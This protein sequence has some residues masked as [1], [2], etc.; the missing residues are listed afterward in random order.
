MAVFDR[1]V[2]IRVAA[3]LAPAAV[4]G[5]LWMSTRPSRSLPHGKIEQLTSSRMFE[6]QPS[7]SPDGSL[8]AFRCDY[9]GNSDICVSTIADNIVRNLTSESRDDESSPS[10]SPDGRTIAFQSG[11]R[12]VFTV[13]VQG[14][15]MTQVTTTGGS[16]AWTPDGRSI[17]YSV[18]TIPGALFRE[19][20]TE[21]FIVDAATRAARR[22]PLVADF[23][24]PAVSPRGSRIAYSG[25]QVPRT[26]RRAFN[27]ASPDLWTVGLDG[28]QAVRVTNDV[29]KESSPMWSADGRFLYFVSDRNGSSAIWRVAIDERTGQPKGRPEPVPT[30]YSQPVRIT[31][32]ADGSRLAWSDALAVERTMRIAFDAEAR[33]T[34]G[35][36]VE[37]SPGTPESDDAEPAADPRPPRAPAGTTNPAMSLAALA[38]PGRWSPDRALYAGTTSGAV[39][40]YSAATR[41]YYQLRPGKS[42]IWLNDGRRLIYAS[43]GKIY[44]AEAVLRIARELLVLADQSLDA[45]RLSPDNRMLY[46]AAEGVDA[47]LWLLTVDR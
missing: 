40:I 39:W 35:A 45:P 31:R 44:I 19:G 41:E 34:R 23:H 20:I 4:A 16:P 10:F 6:G 14:G 7:L 38:F 43:E 42:P 36:P 33:T 24:E 32:S 26:A 28:R 2:A 37:I 18:N 17:V 46:F 8:I 3:A 25:R 9:R 29:A 27:N 22:I 15:P 5:A 1:V 47:N 21:G 13:P 30:P 11:T 12:G